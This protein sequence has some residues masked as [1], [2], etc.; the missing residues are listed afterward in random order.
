MSAYSLGKFNFL[1][2]LQLHTARSNLCRLPATSRVDS[3]RQLPSPGSKPFGSGRSSWKKQKYSEGGRQKRFDKSNK[4]FEGASGSEGYGHGN[5]SQGQKRK[6]P[7]REQ[8][9][10]DSW[11][12]AKQKLSQAEFQQRIKTGSCI[13]CGE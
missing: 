10:K 1:S 3:Q 9:K 5:S 12:K 7:P 11:I 8:K 2:D 6:L 4:P 13:N